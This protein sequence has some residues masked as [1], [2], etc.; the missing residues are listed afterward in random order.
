[1]TQYKTPKAYLAAV[2]RCN[3]KKEPSVPCRCYGGPY[4][5]QFIWLVTRGTFPFQV[6]DWHERY[7]ES[8]Q[9]IPS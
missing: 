4:D 9:W 1:M 7:D 2:K 3:K 8:M 5:R 6:G